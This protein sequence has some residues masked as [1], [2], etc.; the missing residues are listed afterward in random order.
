M[1]DG[2]N[3]M[4]L[5]RSQ[6]R[7]PAALISGVLL[8]AAYPPAEIG[9]LAWIAMVPLLIA[10]EDC[11]N[12]F[13][14]G[15]AFGIV[16]WVYS[17]SWLL[18]V[19]ALGWIL[20][21]LYCAL[22]SGLFGVF[23]RGVSNCCGD[24][25]WSSL[26][27]IFA[28]SLG[29][30][31]IEWLRSTLLSGFPWN[32]LGVSQY[33]NTV[34]IQ[35]CDWGGVYVLSVVIF[36]VNA[37]IAL[38][39]GRHFRS[40][41]EQRRR[42]RLE[43]AAAFIIVVIVFA[44]GVRRLRVEPSPDSSEIRVALV[45]PN[46]PQARKWDKQHIETIFQRLENL[47]R[48]AVAS[49]DLLVWPET[50]TPDFLRDSRKTFAILDRIGDGETEFMIGSMD[51]SVTEDQKY[52]YYNSSFLIGPEQRIL[53]KYDKCHLVLFGEYVPLDEHLPF[54]STFTP[55]E[56][57]F[58]SGAGPKIFRSGPRAIP[59]AP[60]ICFEDTFDYLSSAA[61]RAGARVLVN[62]TNDA[63]FDPSFGSRQ[64]LAQS[65]F[66][67]VE[68]RVPLLRAAN[69]GA[70][71]WIDSK[72]RIRKMLS[73]E[74]GELRSAGFLS[75]AVR[76]PPANMDLSFATVSGGLFGKVCAIIATSLLGIVLGRAIAA[77]DIRD[78]FRIRRGR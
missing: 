66:R 22:Y 6:W 4:D 44:Y 75:A 7:V 11:R 39:I 21:A 30:G 61:V 40:G 5:L 49:A 51:Y 27:K 9:Q 52:K 43:L 73:N 3:I 10:L 31:G 72:G 37:A 69:T 1:N 47:S 76:V 32:N 18:Q 33:R 77:S 38:S 2:Y 65:V 70:S 71:A 28:A 78:R 62:Q 34:M 19:S 53:D 14:L 35:V 60:L 36:L 48:A 50:A 15:F 58:D 54:L 74:D 17:L 63:W 67:A 26:I 46:I 29:W 41:G 24:R 68:N 13:R 45:Q 16:F 23:Y 57:S 55:I 20:L 59:L 25:C 64:H 12:P 42:P 56:G 8:A